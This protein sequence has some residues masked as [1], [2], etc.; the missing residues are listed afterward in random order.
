MSSEAIVQGYYFART[1]APVGA[2][3]IAA[4][5]LV[6]V[7]WFIAT[8]NR[9]IRLGNL[10]KESWS[11][12]DVVLKRRYDLIPNLVETVRGYA[13][14]EREVLAEVI[15]ARDRAAASNGRAAEQAADEN[16]LVHSVNTLLARAEAYPELKAN[17]N[18][19]ALQQ[20]LVNTEDRIAAARRFYN[21]N[22]REHNTLVDQFPSMFV[23]RMMGRQK[24]DFFEVEDLAIRM[25]PKVALGV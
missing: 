24:V 6:P 5:V 21:A 2:I 7:V 3:V 18:F 17:Q 16:R 19:L 8:L 23:A 25:A 22:V 14:H 15:A 4:V 11:N 1:E 13:K 20:E 10:I 12:V 9:F